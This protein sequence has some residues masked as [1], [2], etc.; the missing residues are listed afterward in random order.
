MKWILILMFMNFVIDPVTQAQQAAVEN[1][2]L[3]LLLW[4]PGGTGKTHIGAMK[5]IMLGGLY[6]NNK[7]LLIRKKKTDLRT[8]LWDKFNELLP[9]EAIVKRNETTM[10]IKMLNGTEF[11]GLGLDSEKEVNKLASMECGA[12]IVEEATEVPEQYYDEKIRRACRLPRVPFHQVMLMCNPSQPTHWIKKRW[13]DRDDETLKR[14]HYDDIYFHENKPFMNTDW[15]DWLEGLSGIFGARYRDGQWVGAEGLVYPYNPNKHSIE[16]FD[17]PDDWLRVVALDFGFSLMHAFCVHWWA[18]SP[19]T[20]LTYPAESW[21]CYRQ[22][23]T[24]GKTVSDLAPQIKKFMVQDELLHKA[25]I[26]DHDADGRAELNKHG[27][28]TRPAIK[29]RIAGQQRVHDLI[30][31]D[32][33]YYFKNSLVEEDIELKMHKL[34]VRT[35]EEYGLY[36]W[37]TKDKEDMITKYDHGQDTSRYGVLTTLGGFKPPEESSSYAPTSVAKR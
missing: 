10:T 4:G 6:P 37:A 32:K 5:A 18:I 9:N 14:D 23:Y 21:F 3:N 31:N 29:K 28:K 16:P 22:I 17:I 24:T 1:T 25:I 12:A 36:T 33:M 35:E 26:C 19:E 2:A 34:P 11:I 8:S 7:V 13:L 27:I 20:F 15:L 30:A